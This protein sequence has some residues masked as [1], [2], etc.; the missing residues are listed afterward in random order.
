MYCIQ[1]TIYIC[2]SRPSDQR[3]NVLK[4]SPMSWLQS[5]KL[6]TAM[7]MLKGMKHD[8][9]VVTLKTDLQAREMVHGILKKRDYEVRVSGLVVHTLELGGVNGKAGKGG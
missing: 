4:T 3:N 1:Y 8:A 5:A 2:V 9:A 7:H 6:E